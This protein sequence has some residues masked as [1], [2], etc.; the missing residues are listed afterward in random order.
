VG[1]NAFVLAPG[2]V[3]LHPRGDRRELAITQLQ[4]TQHDRP[5]ALGGTRTQLGEA[6]FRD[7]L[8]RH[9]GPLP[10]LM[11]DFPQRGPPWAMSIDLTTCTG[12]TACVMA[13]SAENNVPVVGRDRVL[14]KRE[15][16]WLRIDRYVEDDTTVMQPMACQHCEK[17]P[18]EYVCPVY[19]TTHSPD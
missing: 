13:C 11:A 12:C 5:I 14:N 17:A 6:R 19:A 1:A 4:L 8:A 9:R 7:E 3:D 2:P 15:M 18:C 16:H 10:S